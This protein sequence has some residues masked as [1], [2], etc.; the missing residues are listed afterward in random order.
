[1][2]PPPT[3]IP[4]PTPTPA[5]TPTP[6]Q[7]PAS[8]SDLGASAASRS[9][10]NLSWNDNSSNEAGFS[11]ERCAGQSCTDFAQVAQVGPNVRF[12][13]DAGLTK[14]T[15]YR[16]RVRAFNADGS[17]GYSNVAAARTLRK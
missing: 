11:I 10:I 3:P 2:P 14:N 7:T 5:P 6:S 17:S 13:A 1:M 8:P 4:T 16:Y 12:Y 15:V 9:Q